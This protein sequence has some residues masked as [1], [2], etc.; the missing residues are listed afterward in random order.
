MSSPRSRSAKKNSQSDKLTN[1]KIAEDNVRKGLLKSSESMASIIHS[2]GKKKKYSV[3]GSPTNEGSQLLM[4]GGF[5]LD[6]GVSGGKSF[7]RLL[8]LSR[9]TVF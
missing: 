4:T 1:N 9:P 2:A 6:A 5:D 7:F 3:L 8:S